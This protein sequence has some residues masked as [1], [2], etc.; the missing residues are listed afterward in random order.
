MYGL[1]TPI[2]LLQ[3]FCVY[4]AYRNNA[5]QRW[6]WLIVFFPLIGCL[7]Y[8]LHNF[9]N[10]TTIDT[11]TENVK[12]A[13]ISNYKL[14]QLEKAL[15]FSDNLKNKTNLADAYVENGRYQD[16]ISLYSACLQGFMSDDPFVQMKLLN[17]HFMNGDYDSAVK[18]GD[19]L[20]S[21]KSFK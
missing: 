4:H 10:R 1:Y 5:E 8:L 9:N 18:Y 6:Y 21:D 20:G 17:A 3:A 12:E 16:A 7:I 13:V 11:L 15:R 2:F 14:E 19:K